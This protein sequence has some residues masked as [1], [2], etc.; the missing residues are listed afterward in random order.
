LTSSRACAAST[1]GQFA[2]RLYRIKQLRNVVDGDDSERLLMLLAGVGYEDR[3]EILPA[4]L[5]LVKVG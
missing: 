2:V 5:E 1:P 3:V 4:A